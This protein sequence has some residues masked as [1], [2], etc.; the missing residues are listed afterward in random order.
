MT[1]AATDFSTTVYTQ[2]GD[3]FLVKS[4][5]PLT[6]EEI[7]VFSTLTGDELRTLLMTVFRFTVIPMS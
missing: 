1:L 7:D 4:H 6:Q 3:P 5:E 2:D